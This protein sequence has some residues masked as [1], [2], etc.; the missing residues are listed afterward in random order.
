MYSAG[1]TAA[2]GAAS[3]MDLPKRLVNA[4][5]CSSRSMRKWTQRQP[6]SRNATRRVGKRSSTPPVIMAVNP[7]SSG[8]RNGM[9]VPG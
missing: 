7:M 2:R 9:M 1:E 4:N 6:A 3:G 8:T 5:R